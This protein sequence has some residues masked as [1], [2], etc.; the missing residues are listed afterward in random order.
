MPRHSLHFRILA[1][2]VLIGIVGIAATGYVLRDLFS[3][4]IEKRFFQ[5]LEST[6]HD[7]VAASESKDGNIR[8]NWRPSD[9]RFNTPFSGW[10][11]VIFDQDNTALT[12]SDSLPGNVDTGFFIY[13]DDSGHRRFTMKG[14]TDAELIGLVRKI[15]PLGSEHFLFF[16]VTGPADDTRRDVDA[17][18][19]NLLIALSL[20][21]IAF[22][23]I[24]LLQL[25][26]ILTPLYKA[27]AGV[28]AIRTASKSNLDQNYPDE[29]RPLVSEINAL[30][31]DNAEILSRARLQASNLAHALK[32]PL[33]VIKN[34]SRGAGGEK[35]RQQVDHLNANISRHLNRVR[36]SGM[37]R[38]NGN[39]TPVA[40]VVR[41]ICESLDIIYSQKQLKIRYDIPEHSFFHGDRLDLEELIGNLMDNACKWAK[42]EVTLST[43][44][45]DNEL[46][47]SVCDD[48]AGIPPGEWDNALKPGSRIDESQNGHGLGLGIVS[49]I[50]ELYG[51]SISIVPKPASSMNCIT[52]KLPGSQLKGLE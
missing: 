48:G 21:S 14:P 17:F 40:E 36:I 30:L 13:P 11:W 10:Y 20:I 44:C 19:L 9:P 27:T 52:L 5:T 15:K 29:I 34:E 37:T 43:Q 1:A 3:N 12:S 4:H 22:I 39:L 51:G 26:W 2:A 38:H 18:S 42:H 28:Q 6:I 45:N 16:V 7:L 49:D 23:V 33:T 35:I 46:E 31:E 50:V 25:R 32:N 24:S 47:L 8:F 41:E